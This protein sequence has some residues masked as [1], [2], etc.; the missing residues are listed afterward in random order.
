MIKKRLLPVVLSGLLM[1][2]CAQTGFVKLG[3]EAIATKRICLA[4]DI[5]VFS[6]ETDVTVAYDKIGIVNYRGWQA[7][8]NVIMS[9]LKEEA[10]KKGGNAI[11]LKSIKPKGLFT[12]SYGTG[13]ALAIRLKPVEK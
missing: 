8:T 11:I 9:W 1:C 4:K 5:Q 2:S 3:P 13:E 6:A 12:Y 10:S 7:N